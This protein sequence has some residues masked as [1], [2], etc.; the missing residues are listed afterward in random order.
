MIARSGGVPLA[1]WVSRLPTST[2][3]AMWGPPI[4]SRARARPLAGHSNRF[5][6]FPCSGDEAM[7]ATAMYSSAAAASASGRAGAG[8]LRGGM[9]FGVWGGTGA[10]RV[11]AGAGGRCS[12]S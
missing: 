8:G 7:V 2:L 10:P 6:P 1:A 5:R 9:R 3:V 4:S 12:A 11:C